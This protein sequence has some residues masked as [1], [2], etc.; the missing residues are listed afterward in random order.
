MNL[1]EFAKNLSHKLH[2]SQTRNDKKTPYTVH[3]DYVG[4]N[5][6]TFASRTIRNSEYWLNFA[7]A[8][9]FLHDSEEDCLSEA[10]LREFG[11]EYSKEF[12]ESEQ[13]F[14]LD[15]WK[16]VVD[17]VVLLSRKD[18]SVPIIEYLNGIKN[19]EIA[20]AVKLC[21]LSHNLSDLGPGNLRDK[22]HL[23]RE[24]LIL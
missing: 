3:T 17:Q 9:G 13:Q 15:E 24:F 5:V 6:E 8:V 23:C 11:K 19:S 14:R 7:K 2:A 18:K 12:S 4:D 21:D 16:Q 1:V 20:T 22:Y 10:E